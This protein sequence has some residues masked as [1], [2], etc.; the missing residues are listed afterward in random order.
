MFFVSFLIFV[1]Y[2]REAHLYFFQQST[3]PERRRKRSRKTQEEENE[4][5]VLRMLMNE[6]D[7]TPIKIRQ[8]APTKDLDE[9]LRQDA[10]KGERCSEA[11]VF[12]CGA[13]SAAFAW[14]SNE[15]YL[16]FSAERQQSAAGQTG[17][18]GP[19]RRAD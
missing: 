11:G 12:R 8:Q 16:S 15:V 1:S 7:D 18:A 5:S 17:L 13:F 19:S 14:T 2:D 4:G 10:A 3:T 9:K 6:E